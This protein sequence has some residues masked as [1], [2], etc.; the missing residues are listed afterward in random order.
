MNPAPIR[1]RIL[2]WAKSGNINSLGD[3][4]YEIAALPAG[5][6][7]LAMTREGAFSTLPFGRV[8]L[9]DGSQEAV[10]NLFGMDVYRDHSQTSLTMPPWS[11]PFDFGNEAQKKEAGENS[12]PVHTEMSARDAIPYVW[13][14]AWSSQTWKPSSC[15]RRPSSACRRH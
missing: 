10:S 7:S 12:G 1:G 14:P 15:R 4:Q 3:I 6:G 8:S 2:L 13:R 11:S 5:G 9:L